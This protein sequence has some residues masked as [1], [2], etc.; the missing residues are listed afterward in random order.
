MSSGFTYRGLHEFREFDSGSWNE[1]D[2]YYYNPHNRV[3][4]ATLDRV[5][6]RLKPDDVGFQDGRLHV[7][8]RGAGDDTWIEFQPWSDTFL[9]TRRLPSGNRRIEDRGLDIVWSC[10]DLPLPLFPLVCAALVKCR[11][12][13][14]TGLKIHELPPFCYQ[15]SRIWGDPEDFSMYR[16]AIEH[17]RKETDW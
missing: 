3:Y 9:V 10:S 11:G 15:S 13:E 6:F 16:N 8:F 5:A 1:I 17:L 2:E 14:K 7:V 4:E 12:Y